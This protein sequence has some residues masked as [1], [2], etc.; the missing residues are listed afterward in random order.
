MVQLKYMGWFLIMAFII[1]IIDIMIS[2]HIIY[3]GFQTT[4]LFRGGILDIRYF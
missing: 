2:I 4:I 3:V 1:F